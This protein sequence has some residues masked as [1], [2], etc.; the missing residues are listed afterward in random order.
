MTEKLI[1]DSYW[2]SIW[3]KFVQQYFLAC[4]A[5]FNMFREEISDDKKYQDVY[6]NPNT[7]YLDFNSFLA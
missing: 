4:P 5:C 2:L 1:R 6:G 7:E 3:P